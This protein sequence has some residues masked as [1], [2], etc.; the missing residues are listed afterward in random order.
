MNTKINLQ[1]FMCVQAYSEN[2]LHTF[3]KIL[4]VEKCFKNRTTFYSHRKKGTIKDIVDLCNILKSKFSFSELYQDF[5]DNTTWLLSKNSYIEID[6]SDTTGEHSVIILADNLTLFNNIENVVVSSFQEKKR[7]KLLH[8]ISPGEDG[9]GNTLY[10]IGEAGIALLKENYQNETI[11][12]FLYIVKQLNSPMPSGRLVILN[13]EA[14]TGKTYFIRGIL[15]EIEF[16]TCILLPVSLIED[17]DKPAIIPL[18]LKEKNNEKYVLDRNSLKSKKIPKEN[19]NKPIILIIEDADFCL[20]PR[21]GDN[22]SAI[23]SLLNYTDG[24]FGSVFDLRIIVTTNARHVEIEKALLRPGRLLSRINIGLL[25]PEKANEIYKRLTSN[26]KVFFEKSVSLA[27]VYAKANNPDFEIVDD[28][29][30][31]S[32]KIGI[33]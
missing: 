27:N 9:E 1:Q 15:N 3:I 14:G 26:E 22:M 6:Q 7:S 10:P 4:L 17:I 24:L 23:S 5:A 2:F 11:N 30:L 8:M 33:C 18:L 20:L 13:G 19:V 21:Q 12:S 28:D 31:N 25:P 32:K 29:D 16:A